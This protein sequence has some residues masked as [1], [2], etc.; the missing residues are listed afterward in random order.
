MKQ[1]TV[2]AAAEPGAGRGRGL[3]A[4]TGRHGSSLHREGRPGLVAVTFVKEAGM[5]EGMLRPKYP[6][7]S[8]EYAGDSTI[9]PGIAN[10]EIRGPYEVRGPGSSPSRERIFVCHQDDDR[11]AQA[12][13]FDDLRGGLIDVQ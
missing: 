1:F 8:Y 5:P 7:T 3:A 9:A 4:G 13:S 6:I 11:C 12:D 2:G 10:V